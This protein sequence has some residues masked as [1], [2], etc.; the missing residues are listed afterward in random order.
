MQNGVFAMGTGR[1][2]RKS[3]Q[4][5]RVEKGKVPCVFEETWVSEVDILG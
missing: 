3:S 5:I 1:E 4:A 2:K